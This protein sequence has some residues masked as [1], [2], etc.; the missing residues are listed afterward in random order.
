MKPETTLALS[1]ALLFVGCGTSDADGPVVDSGTH[2][3][4]AC[5]PSEPCGADYACVCGFCTTTCSA[6]E[7]CSAGTATCADPA[8][9][10]FGVRCE[11]Q[12]ELPD[13][14]CVPECAVDG[15]CAAF[16]SDARCVDGACLPTPDPGDDDTGIADAGDTSVDVSE[17]ARP[18]GDDDAADVSDTTETSD[19]PDAPD[20][21]DAGDTADADEDPVACIDLWDPVC[22]ADGNTYANTCYLE[23][24][25]VEQAHEGECETCRTN[26]DCDG[27]DICFPPTRTCEPVCEPDCVA[28]APVCGS[29]G[30]TYECGRQDA[31]CHGATV[32]YA[33]RCLDD[34]VPCGDDE[35]GPAPGAP[36]YLC[37][38]GITTAGP[39]CRRVDGVCGW[40]LVEC[41]P[42]R[43]CYS[44]DD[45]EGDA[46]CSAATICIGDPSCP[47]CDVCY[48]W[49]HAAEFDCTRE[50]CGGLPAVPHRFCDDGSLAGPICARSA[51]E[52]AWTDVDCPTD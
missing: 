13:A 12:A 29:D 43:G 6:A 35:C 23:A 42:I 19:A 51:G 36:S 15:E 3:M 10:D 47:E 30:E 27:G 44:D 17:D 39:E 50:D 16:G 1:V 49:C 20:A 24:A 46:R 52:C 45:C 33:G 38:D 2:W 9:L 21:T 22:G 28:P 25:G 26:D 34:T 18:D 41:E 7:P 48:G 40:T 14:V 11:G 32:A 31:W 4:M 37:P 8:E 5:D